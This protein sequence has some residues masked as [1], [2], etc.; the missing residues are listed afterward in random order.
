MKQM[1]KIVDKLYARQD[2]E[3]FREPVAWRELG[4]FDYPEL[5]K[6]PMSLSEVKAKLKAGQYRNPAECADDVN[7]IWKNCMTYNMD[8]S[9]FHKLANKLKR[10]FQDQYGKLKQSY[11]EETALKALADFDRTP[12]ID[13]QTQFAHNLYMIK[14]EELGELITKLD[15]HCPNAL[16]KKHPDKDELEIN[17]DSIDGRTFHMLV[18]MIRGFLPDKKGPH[19]GKRQ[20]A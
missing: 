17:I 9:D 6:Q 12:T 15:E 3:P 19:A 8:G 7:L 11:E 1:E 16:Y 4:L 5:I 13:E 18:A 2:V 10:N 14:S 20:R